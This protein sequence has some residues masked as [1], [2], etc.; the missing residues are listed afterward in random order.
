MLITFAFDR[1]ILRFE[2]ERA[3]KTCKFPC[4]EHYCT[5]GEI[6]QSIWGKMKLTELYKEVTGKDHAGAHR[7]L[8]DLE[9]TVEILKWYKKE[10]HI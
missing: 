10:G 4:T 2:L 3:D 5:I 7:S 9:A 6:G 8:D 1:K